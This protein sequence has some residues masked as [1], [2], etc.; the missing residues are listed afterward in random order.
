MGWGLKCKPK[1]APWDMW[2]GC[3]LQR[4][5]QHFLAMNLSVVTD[6]SCKRSPA[7]NKHLEAI[8]VRHPLW[9]GPCPSSYVY[10]L[11]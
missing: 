10:W 4:T 8:A 2:V 7:R 9:P 3:W 11:L 1:C 6:T 5:E